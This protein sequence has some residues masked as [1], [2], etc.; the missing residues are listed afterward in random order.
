MECIELFVFRQYTM[1]IILCGRA[2]AALFAS[3]SRQMKRRSD[4]ISIVFR[5]PKEQCNVTL[6]VGNFICTWHITNVLFLQWSAPYP[7]IDFGASCRRGVLW[8]R[9][10][11]YFGNCMPKIRNERINTRIEKYMDW[12]FFMCYLPSN[13]DPS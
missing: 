2:T 13:P 5:I 11:F 4:E 1:L 8:I 7:F 3:R 9:Q 12:S 10:I 6:W